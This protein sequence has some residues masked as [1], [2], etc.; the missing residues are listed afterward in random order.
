MSNFI[1]AT[2]IWIP[3]ENQTALTL[4]SGLYGENIELELYSK[5][6]VFYYNYGLP[7]KAWAMGH[8]IVLTDLEESFFKRTDIV[9]ELGL[10]SAIAMPI[11]AGEYLRAVVVFLCGDSE[12]H[13]GAIELWRASPD[14]IKEMELVNG[15]YGTMEE[16]AWI[17]KSI[18]I[19]KGQGLPGNAWKNSA[20]LIMKNL[21]ESATFMRAKKAHKEGITTALAIPAW[22]D[23]SDGYIMTFLSAKGTPIARRFEIWYPDHKDGTLHF[24]DGYSHGDVNL[25]ELY[26]GV[27]IQ[28]EESLLG[29]SWRRGLP[30]LNKNS[31]EEHEPKDCDYTL[32]IPV[33]QN[34]FCQA[35]I[36]FYY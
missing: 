33:I 34:G 6:I 36:R 17:S 7:G 21:G 31:Q 32:V 25:D 27:V 14:R 29:E 16:F 18:K 20:P 2:E 13:A 30:L 35:L 24:Q 1:K 23:E 28:K 19:M 3:N 5:N 8:P 9:K 26:D 4:H 12:E 10:T 15:Y 22:I 11:F